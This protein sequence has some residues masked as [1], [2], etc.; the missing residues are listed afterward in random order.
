[1]RTLL[2]DFFRFI[3]FGVAS[4]T[5]FGLCYATSP[6]FVPIGIIGFAVALAIVLRHLSRWVSWVSF[7]IT[8][9]LLGSHRWISGVAL[10]LF[11]AITFYYKEMWER[12]IK[13]R[14]YQTTVYLSKR[15]AVQYVITVASTL[16]LQLTGYDCVHH[17]GYVL[18]LSY[19][20][21]PILNHLFLRT[22][23]ATK[24]VRRLYRQDVAVAR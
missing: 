22:L 9:A 2:G 4:I 24:S 1:M 20:A 8:T 17:N 13:P 21:S 12:R 18:T 15:R 19:K 10:G 5:F 11:V 7:V 16:K 23:I 6:V 14:E 3:G